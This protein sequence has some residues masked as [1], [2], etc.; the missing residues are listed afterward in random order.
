[1]IGNI[2]TLWVQPN[3]R[4]QGLAPGL[5]SRAEDWAKKG[6]MIFM[7]TNVHKDNKRMLKIN[8]SNG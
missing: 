6:R 1:M 2:I 8:E 5:K 4:N 7:Q 3:F